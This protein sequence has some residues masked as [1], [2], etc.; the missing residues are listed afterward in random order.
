MLE[1][2]VSIEYNR[3]IGKDTW[4]MGFCS[5]D[6]AF[7][8]MPGQ[9]LMV[10]SGKATKDP[11]LRR[12][13]SIHGI[14]DNDGLMI[15]Y[16]VVGKGTRLL[17][18][19]KK[20]NTIS[21]IGPLGNGFPLPGPHERILLVAGGM[22]IAPIFFLTQV[23]Q[24]ARSLSPALILGFATSQNVVR[25]QE[26]RDMSVDISLSTED[27]SAGHKGLVTD[28]MD[29]YLAHNAHEKPTVYACGPTPMLKAVARRAADARIRCYVSLEG[30]MACGLQVCLGCAVKAA[31]GKA[32]AYH[33]VCQNGPVFL[34]EIIDWNGMQWLL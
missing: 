15:L 21:V 34:S 11:L 33:Y 16:K 20:D 10:H 26:L 5:P 32:K 9:F 1:A 30:Y 3:Q 8:A 4:L 14:Q 28:L 23:L 25:V 12:P 27:G 2:R 24:E 18:S 6:L 17:S 7:H 29:D 19:L 13:F 31:D 22:G